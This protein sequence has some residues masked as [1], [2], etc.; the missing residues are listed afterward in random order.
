MWI[1]HVDIVVRDGITHRTIRLLI[2][3]QPTAGCGRAGQ[4]LTT[5]QVV[6]IVAGVLS[7]HHAN[8]TVQFPHISF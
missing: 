7:F 1:A 4:T 3:V 6:A 2:V 8:G 5:K